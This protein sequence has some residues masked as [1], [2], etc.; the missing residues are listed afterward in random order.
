[1]ATKECLQEIRN[2][3]ANSYVTAG[4]S[5]AAEDVKTLLAH[6]TLLHQWFEQSDAEIAAQIR[7][8]H[9]LLEFP[10]VVVPQSIR[11]ALKVNLKGG[12]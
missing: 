2:R 10:R 4:A 12:K 5:A 8:E 11:D 6:I 3:S 7:K 1:M 9:N